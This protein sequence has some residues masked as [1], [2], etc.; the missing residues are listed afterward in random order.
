[1]DDAG[2]ER[3]LGRVRD[4]LATHPDTRGQEGIE[5]PYTTRAYRLTPS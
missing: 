3:F 1:M 5:L 4:L 2:R